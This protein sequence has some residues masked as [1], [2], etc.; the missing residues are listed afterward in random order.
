[1]DTIQNR[2]INLRKKA[3][4]TQLELATI[5]N[6]SHQAV[7]KWERGENIPDIDV[8]IILSKLYNVSLDYLLLGKKS[9]SVD[10]DFAIEYLT[11][12]QVSELVKIMFDKGIF[13][14]PNNALD[15]IVPEKMVELFKYSIDK[16]Q[17]F[18]L[19]IA[20]EHAMPEDVPEI[21]KELLKNK[22]I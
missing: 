5:I 12:N 9:I 1:M 8:F 13:W 11:P 22:N 10:I 3:K 7:S 20:L 15:Y 21:I 4:I 18:D 19:N 17:S 14:D 2:M 16:G 6:I